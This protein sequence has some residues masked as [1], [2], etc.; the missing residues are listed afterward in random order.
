MA[1]A[2]AM[3]FR[4]RKA[5]EAWLS[6]HHNTSG[7]LWLRLA[8]KSAGLKSVTHAEAL[9]VAL[10]YGW[11]DGQR[12]GLDEQYWLQRFARNVQKAETRRKRIEQ[13]V[14][15]LERREKLYP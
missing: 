3:L 6:K 7:G 14:D 5:W 13:L 11:I 4:N 8:R 10:S 2:P 1:S 12:K 9:E 15:M